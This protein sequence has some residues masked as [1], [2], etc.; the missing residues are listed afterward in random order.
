M[1]DMVPNNIVSAIDTEDEVE[2][3]DEEDTRD[4]NFVK[5]PLGYICPKI[6]GDLN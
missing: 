3:E 4:E 1:E 2:E 6:Y 5:V